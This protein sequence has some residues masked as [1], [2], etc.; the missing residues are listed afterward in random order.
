MKQST[1]ETG[2]GIIA[3]GYKTRNYEKPSTVLT[4]HIGA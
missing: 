2:R 3:L 1:S 4:W